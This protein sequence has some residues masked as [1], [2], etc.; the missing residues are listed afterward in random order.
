MK[1]LIPL[2]CLVILHTPKGTELRLESRH[3]T[4][5]QD[6]HDYKGAAPGSK[7]VVNSG[8][9]RFFVVETVEEIDELLEKCGE[10]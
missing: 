9:Q 6:L 10:D 1:K 4:V 3:I 2:L 5:F 7:S 8:S